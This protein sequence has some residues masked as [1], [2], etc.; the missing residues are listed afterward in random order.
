MKLISLLSKVAF[1]MIILFFLSIE[2]FPV[3]WLFAGSIKTFDDL[4]NPAII[5]PSSIDLIH[6]TDKPPEG[7]LTPTLFLQTRNSL[8]IAFAVSF[9]VVLISILSAYA[10]A[11]MTFRF[12]R[13]YAQIILFSYLF[14]GT[15]LIFPMTFLLLQ[16]GLYNS[17]QGLIVAETAVTTPFAIW[18]LTGY[19]KSLPKEIEESAMV[20]G[21][22]RISVI[23]RIV[24]PLSMP[25]I[26]AVFMYA[27][28]QSWNNYLFPLILI[29]D[30]DLWTLAVGVPSLIGSDII[31]WGKMFAMSSLY[32]LPA[33]TLFF[34]L[35]KYIVSGLTKGAVKA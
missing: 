16:Y 6:Y 17:L 10:L 21:C 8:L 33:V 32:A 4:L 23:T 26:V 2:L 7:I 19:F 18:L 20:D 22:G 14:P 29:G 5:F 13:T 9:L 30:Q 3:Y 28:L 34:F 1:Y 27:F 11:R 35:N 25:A 12:S 31:P 24:L 15:V